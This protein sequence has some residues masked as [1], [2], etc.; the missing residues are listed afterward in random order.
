MFAPIDWLSSTSWVLSRDPVV[1]YAVVAIR[2]TYLS[3][4]DCTQRY[5]SLTISVQTSWILFVMKFSKDCWRVNVVF[6]CNLQL[7]THNY[8]FVSAPHTMVYEIVWLQSLLGT[9]S[10]DL[11]ITLL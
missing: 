5:Y 3:Y 1:Q 8:N 4:W 7:Q 11:F 10:G 6:P 9:M 2:N